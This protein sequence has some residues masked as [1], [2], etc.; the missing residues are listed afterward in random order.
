MSQA[1]LRLG[2]V[3]RRSE[4]MLFNNIGDEVVM[5]DIEQGSYYGLEKVAARIW[6]LTEQPASV[7]SLCDWLTAEY[8]VTEETCRQEV[9]AFVGELVNRGIVNIVV[10]EAATKS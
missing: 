1:Q 10:A 4:A 3:V 2:M 6:A 7:A 9:S 8:D 5:M